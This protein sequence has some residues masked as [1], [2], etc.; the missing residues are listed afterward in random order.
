LRFF[1]ILRQ[2]NVMLFKNLSIRWH[3]RA[4]Q[5]AVTAANFLGEALGELGMEILSFPDFGAEKRGAPVIVFNRFS[6]KKGTPLDPAQPRQIDLVVLLEPSLVGAELSHEE[7]L[8]GLKSDGTLVINTEK[9]EPS[10]FAE[11]FGGKIV[12]VPATKIA[13]ETLGKN[14]PN[15]AM[16]G[17]LAEILELPAEKIKKLL[18][19]NLEKVFAKSVVEK[20]LV[21]FQRGKTELKI[22]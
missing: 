15:V 19:K 10:K 21:G 8:K 9:A 13:R 11:K 20:N 17:A 5:G 16:I 2:S 12:H 14:L 22:F 7:I 6:E 3:S 4:G 1:K 18:E